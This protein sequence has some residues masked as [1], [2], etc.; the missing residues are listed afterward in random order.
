MHRLSLCKTE[1][2]RFPFKDSAK[3]LSSICN[4]PRDKTK[5]VIIRKNDKVFSSAGHP[6]MGRLVRMAGVFFDCHPHF[7]PCL[8]MGCPIRSGMTRRMAGRPRMRDATICER[9]D[10][11]GRAKD[12]SRDGVCL[13]T[14]RLAMAK[15]VKE[16][17]AASAASGGRCGSLCNSRPERQGLGRSPSKHSFAPS[18]SHE[19]HPHPRPAGIR[20]GKFVPAKMP[21]QGRTGYGKWRA[22]LKMGVW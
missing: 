20:K 14:V 8:R 1:T 2:A 10:K 6:Q 12:P 11:G 9:K 19:E 17:E 4:V 21:G 22:I 7:G 5:I 13:T 15:T 16:L 18:A 3:T